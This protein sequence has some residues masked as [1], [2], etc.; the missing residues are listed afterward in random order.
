MYVVAGAS[1]NT[2][3]VVA[4]VLLAYGQAV[5]VILRSEAK[6]APW[7]GLGAE[8][9][10]GDIED[11]EVLAR[12]LRGAAG[13]YLLVPPD[14]TSPDPVGRARRLIDS[15]A[16]AVEA[17]GVPHVTFLSSVG[18]Q[19]EEG[20]GIVRTLYL[21]E[22]RLAQFGAAV[23]FL[24]AAAFMENL[25]SSIGPALAGGTFY[26]FLSPA[27]R[28]IPMVATQDIG[29]VAAWTLLLPSRGPRVIE[30]AGPIDYSPAE[31]AAVVSRLSGK[32]IPA[33]VAPQEGMA[34]MLQSFGLSLEMAQ[35]MASLNAAINSGHVAFSQKDALFL[36]GKTPLEQVLGPLL[37]ASGTQAQDS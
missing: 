31:V 10:L 30:L 29:E 22:Q 33:A 24:R 11:A 4:R 35:E 5:R 23:T 12:A 17:S 21:G 7:R 8:V 25:A 6:A 34:P 18:A 28:R 3:A 36:R 2:G 19:H 26:S 32:N 16:R 27:D 15:V 13:A 37:P 20:T 14:P 1:G 9:A